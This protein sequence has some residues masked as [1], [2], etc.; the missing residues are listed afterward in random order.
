M[1]LSRLSFAKADDNRG[2]NWTIDGPT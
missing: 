1:L 2:R